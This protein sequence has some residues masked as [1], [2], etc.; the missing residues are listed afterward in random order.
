MFRIDLREIEDVDWLSALRPGAIRK[1]VDCGAI[2]MGLFDERNLFE[3]EHPDWPDERL[4]ACRNPELAKRRKA[5]RDSL[6]EATAAELDKVRRMVGRGRLHGKKSIGDRV[7]KILGQ[8]K[9][10]KYYTVEIRDDG[11][12]YEVD[13]EVLS[14]DVKKR[15]G[16]DAALAAK[17][18]ER[19]RR[20]IESIA[21]KLGELRERLERG[22]LHGKD[23]IGVRVGRVV[24]KYKVAKHFELHIE[25]D[26]FHF[27]INQ[28]KVDVER[29]F[30]CL[31]SV[32]L[33]VRPIRHRRE[34]RVRA[35]NLLCMLAYYVQWHMIEAWRPLLFADEDQ[36]SKQTR[37]PV[38]PAKRSKEARE[39]AADKQLEDGSPVHSF[40]NLLKHLHE[41][42]RNTCRC[43]DADSDK[44]DEASTFHKTTTPNP[45]QQRALDLLRGITVTTD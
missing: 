29:A 28:Q 8:Y 44:D 24:N 18:L 39:K 12:D 10:G 19:Y 25:D 14:A 11:F 43:P 37:D 33:M 26:S 5:K 1:L 7:G 45:K 17:R 35:H 4:I 36:V 22:R 13:E 40:I 27:D 30:R 3:L 15:A 16:A 21:K 20:H 38:A 32:D 31:K 9:V 2:Q 34:R 23:E 42:V 41:I 6:L